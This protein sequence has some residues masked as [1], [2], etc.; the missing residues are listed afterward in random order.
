VGIL[1]ASD[2]L[3]THLIAVGDPLHLSCG[4]YL[5]RRGD[6]VTGVFLITNGAVRLGLEGDLPAFPWRNLGPGSLLG[7]PATLS[8]ATYSLTAEVTD[9]ADLIFLPRQR[10]LD[11]LR[12]QHH[13]C[14]QIM[15]ILSEELNQTRAALARVRK[16]G[17]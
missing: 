6:P 13:L 2:E 9:D 17:E 3:R 4:N 8:E 14:F 5:F 10:L 12:Q 15:N 1:W 7:L 16:H 11:L